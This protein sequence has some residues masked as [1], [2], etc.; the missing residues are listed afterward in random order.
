MSRAE[1]TRPTDWDRAYGK[2]NRVESAN[3]AAR[4]KLGEIEHGSIRT[5]KRPIAALWFAM[6]ALDIN[7][8][9]YDHFRQ[10]E[11]YRASDKPLSLTGT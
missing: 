2:R 5:L 9:A 11:A 10:R 6:R 1:A 3:A 8:D 7:D 4:V